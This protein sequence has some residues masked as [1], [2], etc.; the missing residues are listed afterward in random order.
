MN[1]IY[2]TNLYLIFFEYNLY[3]LKNNNNPKPFPDK[4]KLQ[5]CPNTN[6]Q[7]FDHISRIVIPYR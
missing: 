4:K 3:F 6:R 1:K 2:R 7:T 5:L